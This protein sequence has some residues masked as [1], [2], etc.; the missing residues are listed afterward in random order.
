MALRPLR[1]PDAGKRRASTRAKQAD[2]A[3]SPGTDLTVAAWAT[4]L[5]RENIAMSVHLDG[6]Q[7]SFG[8]PW[9]LVPCATVIVIYLADSD[10]VGAYA[11]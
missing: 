4:E 2:S 8:L 5:A 1:I 10:W 11:D 6:L 3:G 7:S 9:L